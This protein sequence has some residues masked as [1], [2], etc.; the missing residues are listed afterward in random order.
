MNPR[1]NVQVVKI[2]PCS[3]NPW[4]DNRQP[5]GMSF[6]AF[7]PLLIELQGRQTCAKG[8]R[9]GYNSLCR[10]RRSSWMCHWFTLALVLGEQLILK[11]AT[12]WHLCRRIELW[13]ALT[14]VL[15][16]RCAA[17]LESLWKRDINRS[18]E[19]HC[20][21]QYIQ[22]KNPQTG[23]AMYVTSSVPLVAR[24]FLGKCISDVAFIKNL[25]SKPLES[26]YGICYDCLNNNSIIMGII[27]LQDWM[28]N[29]HCLW[30]AS[31]HKRWQLL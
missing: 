8:P 28:C 5:S 6:L 23:W 4:L 17:S 13:H 20:Y 10:A 11:V 7:S 31:F 18:W 30:A 29:K 25:Y 26:P 22:R 12:S 15:K 19:L 1:F 24:I 3:A 9:L 27:S 14:V 21:S 16:T 2:A